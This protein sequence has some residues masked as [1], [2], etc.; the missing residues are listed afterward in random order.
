MELD[1]ALSLNHTGLFPYA[2]TTLVRFR[3]GSMVLLWSIS[4]SDSAN[5]HQISAKKK[6]NRENKAEV[7]V[8]EK[9]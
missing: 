7:R 9:G 3:L 1:Q 4:S 5:G 2:V 6:Y 8:K